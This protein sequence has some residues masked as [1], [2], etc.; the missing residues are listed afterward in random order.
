MIE[1]CEQE[2]YVAQA[3]LD[4]EGFVA[5]VEKVAK[6]LIKLHRHASFSLGI[7]FAG[8]LRS[9]FREALPTSVL[10]VSASPVI[11]G[12]IMKLSS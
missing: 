1:G 4:G 6:R 8:A 12:F 3:Q 10:A 5:E 9:Y 2:F 11:S 7:D